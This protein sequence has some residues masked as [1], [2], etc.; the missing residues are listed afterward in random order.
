MLIPSLVLKQL[1]TFGSLSNTAYGVKFTLKNRLSDAQLTGIHRI[2]IA[3]KE[4]PL[5]QVELD[6]GDGRVLTPGNIGKEAPLDFPLRKTLV[7]L[8]TCDHLPEGRHR[9]EVEKWIFLDDHAIQD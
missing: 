5:A 6:N 7:V 8:C 4:V 9:I 3:G 1:H 2:S